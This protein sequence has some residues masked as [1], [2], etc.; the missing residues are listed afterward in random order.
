MVRSWGGRLSRRGAL[1]TAALAAGALAGGS[2]LAACAATGAGAAAARPASAGGVIDLSFQVQWNAPWN[3]TA[4]TLINQFVDQNFN[5]RHKGVRATVWPAGAGGSDGI[6][7]ASLAGAP[8]PDIIA[9]CC[10]AIPQYIDSGWLLPLESYLQ[11]SNLSGGL[12]STG[13]LAALQVGGHQYGLPSYDGPVVMAYRQDTLDQLGF[14]YPNPSWTYQ[15]ATTLWEQCTGHQGG[16]P[17]A[18]VAISWAPGIEYLLKGWGGDL[19]DAAR[20]TCL[21]GQTAGIAAGKWFY[22]LLHNHVAVY[23]NGPYGLSQSQ[24]VFSMCGGWDVFNMATQL[25]TKIKWDILPVPTWPNGFSTFDNNDFYGMNRATKNPGVAWELLR[26]MTAEPAWP[27]FEIKTTLTQPGLASLWSEWEQIIVAAAP[28]LRGKAIHY[29]RD[30]ALS[31]RAYPHYFF[32]YGGNR[33][34]GII[35]NGL[36][37]I[38]AGNLSVTQGFQQIA[39]AVNAYETTSVHASSGGTKQAMQKL[40]PSKG[41]DVA[42]VPPDL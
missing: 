21:L 9:D 29:F 1:R 28:P 11:Q 5:A 22:N 10:S 26:W 20:T 40:F 4:Q 35:S 19:M 24:E 23:Y 14:P 41:A 8:T 15:E 34:D 2:A 13:H 33:A 16:K 18:G 36:N 39:Q 42:I 7:A 27:R 6:I 12:W 17:R 3:S 30:A 38:A 32:R 25:G 37:H 31:G